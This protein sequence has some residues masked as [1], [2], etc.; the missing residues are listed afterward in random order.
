MSLID[1]VIV[2][3]LLEGL[4]LAGYHRRTGRGMAPGDF[5]PNLAAGLA[6]MLALR[7]G[8]EGAGWGYVAAGLMAAGLAHAADLKGRWRRG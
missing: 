1:V 4:A 2:L 6:L 8:L 3:T 7:A 5:M